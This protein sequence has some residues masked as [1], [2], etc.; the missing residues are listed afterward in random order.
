M[1]YARTGAGRDEASRRSETLIA[2]CASLDSSSQKSGRIGFRR[3]V[4]EAANLIPST[5]KMFLKAWGKASVLILDL[6]KL[7][8]LLSLLATG[9]RW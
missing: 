6:L 1:A 7:S 2:G 8:E 9:F 4:E 3:V 5:A